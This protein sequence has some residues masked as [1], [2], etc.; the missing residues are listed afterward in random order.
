MHTCWDVLQ[1]SY[2][3]LYNISGIDLGEASDMCVC[4]LLHHV[5]LIINIETL[6]HISIV[7]IDW[8]NRANAL[9]C[10]ALVIIFPTEFLLWDAQ[11][12]PNHI[13]DFAHLCAELRTNL[14]LGCAVFDQIAQYFGV[15]SQLK[16][17][18]SH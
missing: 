9:I 1:I 8:L 16:S 13:V 6:F 18:Q 10:L 17:F 14:L 7:E 11:T 12:D 5:Y 3:D 2:Q 15:F 4:A